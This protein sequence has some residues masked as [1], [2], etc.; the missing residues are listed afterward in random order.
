MTRVVVADDEPDILAVTAELLGDAGYEVTCVDDA[1]AILEHVREQGPAVLL[2]DLNMAGL[3]VEDLVAEIRRD[4]ALRRT[5]IVL[6][7]ASPTAE[8]E[9][10][11]LGADGVLTKPYSVEALESVVREAA[12]SM[13]NTDAGAVTHA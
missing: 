7:S 12:G 8:A 13:G 9:W 2:Q 6:F 4:P 1:R 5:R 3:A 11:R 10:R